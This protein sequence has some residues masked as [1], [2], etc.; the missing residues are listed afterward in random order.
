MLKGIKGRWIKNYIVIPV[1]I[2]LMIEAFFI[3]F[4]KDYYY[5]LIQTNL[6]NKAE[7]S[8]TFYNKYLGQGYLDFEESVKNLYND[9][10]LDSRVETQV[11]S[12]DGKV[13]Y[14]S[15]GAETGGII[16]SIDF[17][18]AINE[19]K[20]LYIGTYQLGEKVMI[21]SLPLYYENRIGGVLRCITS[22][23][24]ADKLIE[25]YILMSILLLG[26][27]IIIMIILSDIFS[28]SI[29]NPINEISQVAKLYASD[30]F[31][32]RLK[33][34]YKD[35]IGDLTESINY[36]ADEISKVQEMKNDFISSISHE[37]RTPL[38]AIK[39][40]SQTLLTG[41]MMEKDE[42]KL[43]LEIIEKETDRLYG[44]VEELLDFSKIEK[45]KLELNM[46]EVEVNVLIDEIYNMFY[47][48]CCL[49]NIDLTFEKSIENIWVQGDYNRLK[50][51]LINV[52][53]NAIKFNKP[54]GTIKIITKVKEDV[55]CIEV[56]DKGIGIDNKDI[57]KV[58]D[59]F[60][61]GNK[62][63]KGSGLGL[64]I[65]HEIIKKHGGKLKVNSKK[66]EGTQVSIFLRIMK[67]RL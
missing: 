51:V 7:V 55:V 57:R 47:K 19:K 38:T 40:W 60:Y 37:L 16:Q 49:K 65:S 32:K 20:G 12:G 11:I 24:K 22:L 62:N 35:E 30:D 66:S 67:C 27:L 13:L 8:A 28:R 15:T 5:G 52:M 39:G 54:E 42:L 14:T 61:K 3:Y 44:L 33:N 1:V 50:Q 31:S 29:I 9:F 53:D 58:T 17:K 10:N 18:E 46:V 36:M 59:K 43:G 6:S 23:G 25:Q 48:R 21:V 2:L 45:H 26:I 63:I 34:N 64:A 4:I 41:E 56:I